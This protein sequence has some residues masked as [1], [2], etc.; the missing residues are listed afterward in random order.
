MPFLIIFVLIPIA[1]VYAFINVGEEIGVFRTL[2][3]CVLTAAIGGLLVRHQGLETLF[4]AQ[5]GLQSGQ[6]PLDALFDG[7]CLVISGALLL[8]P[9]FVTDT[10]GFALLIPPLREGLRHLITKYGKFN[11]VGPKTRAQRPHNDI[12]GD[13]IEGDYEHVAK[14]DERL[15]KS[16]KDH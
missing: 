11:I 3:L 7:F 4:K 6:L 15:D 9:G 2:L 5:K 14:D 1:E 8:T 16:N 13:I 12:S 10:V